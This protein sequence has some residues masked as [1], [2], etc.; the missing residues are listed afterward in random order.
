MANLSNINNKFVVE[1]T[2]GYVGIGT[3]D[4]NFLIEAAGTN[5]E[6]ALNSTSASIYRVRS[7]SNDEFIITK[8]GVADRLVIS[9]GGNVGIGTSSPSSMLHLQSASSPTLRIVDTTNNATLLAYAQNSDAHIGT[10]SNHDLI[11][12]T[13]SSERMRVDSSGNVGI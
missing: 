5:S 11:F 9:G 2:T 3:T 8:N 6:I 7:T 4:P 1:Q 12:D 13:N 10:Y